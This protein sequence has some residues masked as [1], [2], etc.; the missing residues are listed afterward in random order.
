MIQRTALS[1]LQKTGAHKVMQFAAGPSAQKNAMS[2]GG[3]RLNEA[4]L[5]LT[6]ENEHS[7]AFATLSD[8]YREQLF[9]AAHRI[10]RTREDAEDAVQDTLL[11]AFV[12]LGEFEGRSNVGTWLTSIA[13][14]SALMLLRKKRA[15]R[16]I[17]TGHNNDF[18]GDDLC[19][20]I[21]DHAPNPE[22]LY[23]QAEE[24]RILRTAIQ[25]LRPNLRVVVQIHLQGRSMRETA[26]ALGISVSAAK[27]RLFHA[28]KALRRSAIRKLVDQPRF[29]GKVCVLRPGLLVAA[30]TRTRFHH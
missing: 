2:R 21:T 28:K 7:T 19:C 22:T 20:E 10:T 6:G 14:N 23:A 27:A 24:Q 26:E 17:A 3:N 1:R 9:R 15:S 12:H 30:D 29:A 13:V 5:M 8:Q 4:S 11:R 16:E 25:R 18:G